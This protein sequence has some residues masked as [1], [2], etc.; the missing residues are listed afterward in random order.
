VAVPL[1]ATPVAPVKFALR[2]STIV[3]SGPLV[4]EN[5]PIDGGV[6]SPRLSTS[7]SSKFAPMPQ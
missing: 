1:N 2:M 6:V 7:T 3:S 5:E 4:G